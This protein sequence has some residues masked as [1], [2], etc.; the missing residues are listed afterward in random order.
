MNQSIEMVA[1]PFA[2][3]SVLGLQL[4]AVSGFE[5]TCFVMLYQ[6]ADCYDV[7]L[8]IDWN[9]WLGVFRHSIFALSL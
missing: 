6:Y 5:S 1:L 8:A 9:D 2:L 7:S 4:A 3:I